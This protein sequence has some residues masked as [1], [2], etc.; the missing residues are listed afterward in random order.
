M[1]ERAHGKASY[2]YAS[3]LVRQLESIS[4]EGEPMETMIQKISSM[5]QFIDRRLRTPLNPAATEPKRP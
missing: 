1:N 4:L 5:I 2:A 3:D